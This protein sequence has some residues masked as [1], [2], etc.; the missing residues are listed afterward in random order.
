MHT[1]RDQRENKMLKSLGKGMTSK[2]FLK[3][4]ETN[5]EEKVEEDQEPD[6]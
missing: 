4:S 6:D 5:V 3:I 2:T 1:T